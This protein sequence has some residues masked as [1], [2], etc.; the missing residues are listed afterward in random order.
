MLRHYKKTKT[1]TKQK[2]SISA[3][4]KFTIPQITPFSKYDIKYTQLKLK[5]RGRNKTVFQ[6][7][8][9]KLRTHTVSEQMSAP[10][11]PKDSQYKKSTITK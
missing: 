7:G 2:P 8:C 3:E 1:E 6:C 10:D 9:P 11:L 5:L 4:A